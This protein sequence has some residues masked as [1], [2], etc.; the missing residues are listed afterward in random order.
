VCVSLRRGGGIGCK[1]IQV[2]VRSDV[3]SCPPD[4]PRLSPYRDFDV[5]FKTS[6][7]RARKRL[8]P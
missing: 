8:T 7:L 3:R 1:A 6:R 2:R 5:S 4:H